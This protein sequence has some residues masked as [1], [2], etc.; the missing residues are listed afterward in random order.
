MGE[1][2]TVN[3]NPNPVAGRSY[4]RFLMRLGYTG[5]IYVKSLVE[6]NEQSAAVVGTLAKIVSMK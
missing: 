2:V 5:T 6:I 3:V 1:S 4:Q